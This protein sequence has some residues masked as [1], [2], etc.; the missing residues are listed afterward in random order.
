MNQ[1]FLFA[2]ITLV[3]LPE[4]CLDRQFLESIERA[5]WVGGGGDLSSETHCKMASLILTQ[6]RMGSERLLRGL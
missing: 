5:G 3:L 2:S 6:N 4:I 1:A